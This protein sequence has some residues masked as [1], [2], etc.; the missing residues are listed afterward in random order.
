MAVSEKL[1]RLREVLEKPDDLDEKAWLYLP[2]AR[3]W[4]LDSD[5]AI[6]RSE[7]V[8]PEMEDDPDA[9]VPVFAKA[10]GLTQAL[11]TATVKEIVANARLQRAEVDLPTLLEAFIYFYDHDAFLQ[12]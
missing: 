12:I 9:G 7:E 6:L 1:V 11:P 5:C 10:N 3:K 8:P 4:D 2:A